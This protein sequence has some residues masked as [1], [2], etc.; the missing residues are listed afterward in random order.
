MAANYNT[1]PTENWALSLIGEG[2][3]MTDL[4][5]INQC[6]LLILNTIKGSDPLRPDFGTEIYKWIDKPQNVAIPNVK[7]EI[8]DNVAL[9]ETRCQI[10]SI[11]HELDTV[12][13]GQVTFSISWKFLITGQTGLTNFN[14]RI[15]TN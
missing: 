1:I 3:V 2:E 10:V 15:S 9:W 5:D 7:K 12:Q 6:I 13:S 11:A 4:E 8:L 14:I